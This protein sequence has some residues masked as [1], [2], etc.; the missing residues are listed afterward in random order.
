MDT[1]ATMVARNESEPGE[2]ALMYRTNA[3]SRVLEEAFLRVNLPYRLVG[4]QRFYGRREV[5]D[6]IAFFRLVHNLNDEASLMR[7]INVPP[8]R[9]GAKTMQ[10]LRRHAQSQDMTMGAV[11]V[12]LR[13][14]A[15]FA[16]FGSF[17][18]SSRH[19][20]ERI[21]YKS[22]ELGAVAADLTPL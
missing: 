16:T 8:R 9:I 20:V 14:G 1:I 13:H 6:M 2:I 15:G 5:K 17:F 12:D 3:Q 10:A 7:V 19:R 4:A 21:W 11:L 22:G 18:Q